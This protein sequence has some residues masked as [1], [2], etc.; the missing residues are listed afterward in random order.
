MSDNAR[1]A[2]GLALLL[3][4]LVAQ[5][6]VGSANSSAAFDETYHLVSGYAY[7]RTG[8]PRLSWEHPPLAQALAAL[9]L[10]TRH[11]LAPFPTD[12]PA[13]L[14]GDREAFVNGYLW[15][16]NASCAAELVWAG[17]WPLMALTA[18]FGLALFVALRETA[19][20]PAA[21]LGLLLFALDPNIT[22][23]GRLITN[24]LPVAGLMFAADLAD[25]PLT[26]A[27][28]LLAR[29]PISGTPTAPD[30]TAVSLPA[31]FQEGPALAGWALSEEHVAAGETLTVTTYWHVAGPLTP[32]LAVFVHLLGENGLPVTQWDGWPVATEGLEEG[33]VVILAHPLLISASLPPGTYPL[34]AGLYRPPNG[35]RLPV[36]GCDRLLLTTIVVEAR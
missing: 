35:P 4:L 8:S 14:A 36:A 18:L 6:A 15:E 11:D 3:A 2:L 20:E 29:I 26:D 28:P 30:G 17:R 12:D 13:W 21:W 16:D 5:M 1:R 25:S 24:D 10:L 34:Q 19:G 33:D 23:N 27:R 32:P 7:L 9:P 22:A 31:V